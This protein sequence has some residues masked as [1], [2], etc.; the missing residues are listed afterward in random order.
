MSIRNTILAEIAEI[1]MQQSKDLAPLADSLP[2]LESGLDSLC[3]AILVATLDEKLGFDPFDGDGP[4]A[5][6]VTIGDFIELY[7]N[8]R[9]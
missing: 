7:E 1:A 8:V 4:A 6:P 3:I 2:I 9:V 5:F